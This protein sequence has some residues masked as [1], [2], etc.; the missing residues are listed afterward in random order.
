MDTVAGSS[1]DDWCKLGVRTAYGG[2]TDIENGW[3]HGA[4]SAQQSLRPREHHNLAVYKPDID[5][6]LAFGA[7]VC[8]PF[9]EPWVENFQGAP[10]SSRAVYLRYRGTVVNEWL[11][12]S[13]DGG[14]YFLPMP[15]MNN[16][17]FEVSR[18]DLPLAR[19]MFDLDSPGGVHK[20]LEAA[21]EF[22][23]IAIVP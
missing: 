16:G 6:S 14:R 23:Q 9:Q 18:A 11:G 3:E 12:V 20:T 8:A 21:L 22:A 5:I 17:S 15:Q 19:L 13:V 7:T 10:A 4:E 1:A 2:E